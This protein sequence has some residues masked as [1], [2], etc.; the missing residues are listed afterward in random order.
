MLQSGN[1]VFVVEHRFVV[2]GFFRVNLILE[3]LRLIFCIVQLAKAV[4]N[5][6]AADEEFKAVGDFRVHVV[7]ARQRRNLC[8]IFG[9]EGRLNQV[10]FRHF[11]EDLSYDAAQAPAF[12]NLDADRF[13]DRFGGVEVIQIG[14]IRFRTVFLD[15]LAHGQFFERLAE[16][17]H[18]IAVRHFSFVQDILRQ[19]TEQRFGQF[20]QVFIVRIRHIEFHHGE[21]WVM[22]NGDPFVT[23]VTVD[24]EHTLEAANHQTLQV[25]FRRDT[26][27]HVQIQR[28]VMGDKRTSCRTARNHLHHRGFHFH[29]A[30][31]NHELTNTRHNL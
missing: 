5:F 13:S 22:T 11:F 31:A 7:T 18:F 8:R 1:V 2:T 25:Q 23:E 16:V 3:T 12:L 19:R 9:D 30:A 17:E 10:R 24:F 29:K 4:T 27:V 20:D 14:H 28:V 21:L 26:Q 6:T 15:S